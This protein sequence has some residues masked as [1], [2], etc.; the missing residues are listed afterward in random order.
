VV[1]VQSPNRPKKYKAMQKERG[2]MSRYSLTNA[3]AFSKN[4]GQM[5]VSRTE[6]GSDLL[7]DVVTGA[8]PPTQAS[9]LGNVVVNPMLMIPNGR[10]AQFSNLYEKFKVNRLRVYWKPSA[11]QQFSGSVYAWH[12]AN[13][14][15]PWNE[16]GLALEQRILAQKFRVETPVAQEASLVIPGAQMANAKDFRYYVDPENATDPTTAY[17]GRI[18]FAMSG[19]FVAS[20]LY[21][22]WLVDWSVTFF[23]PSLDEDSIARGAF[24]LGVPSGTTNPLGAPWTN[25]SGLTLPVVAEATGTV[26]KIT[27]PRVGSYNF[28]YFT[29]GSGGAALTG[30]TT[31]TTTAGA[32]NAGPI[33]YSAAAG[34]Q[35]VW[36][37]GFVISIPGASA[38]FSDAGGPTHPNGNGQGVISFLP[39]SAPLTLSEKHE[40]TQQLKESE[41]DSKIS[42]LKRMLA[43]L[44]VGPSIAAPGTIVTDYNLSVTDGNNNP[45]EIIQGTVTSNVGALD[46]V[47]VAPPSD[48]RK[49][50]KSHSPKFYLKKLDSDDEEH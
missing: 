2:S 6:T 20:T 25:G 49:I 32:I 46:V 40:L 13:P 27:F 31:V 43:T 4:V 30:T 28:A 39:S 19:P 21:G 42:E 22:S 41:M 17:A 44:N 47:V 3:S 8:V 1:V 34:V 9:V 45:P 16:A 33:V 18:Y 7:F 5:K 10:L 35:K 11:S 48:K 29:T 50:P 14:L 15:T 36:M 38:T 23:D 37:Y 24:F 12:S 26:T